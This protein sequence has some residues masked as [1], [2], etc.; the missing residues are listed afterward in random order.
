MGRDIE[1]VKGK[2]VSKGK[3]VLAQE[4]RVSFAI[5]SKMG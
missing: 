5:F 1:W 3:M 2:S 4:K